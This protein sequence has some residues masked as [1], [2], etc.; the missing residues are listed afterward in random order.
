[1]WVK[2]GFL[3]NNFLIHLNHLLFS[4]DKASSTRGPCL[5]R[6]LVEKKDGEVGEN[7]EGN[8]VKEGSRRSC[9]MEILSKSPSGE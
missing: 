9:P 3:L 8:G 2:K 6:N 4:I 1:M 7:I 5:G